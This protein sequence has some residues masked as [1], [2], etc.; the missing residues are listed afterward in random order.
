[1]IS[2]VADAVSTVERRTINSGGSWRA[3][4]ANWRQRTLKG[5]KVL[6]ERVDG[7]DREQMRALAD[8]LRNKWKSA[9][10]CWRRR[11]TQPSRSS[12][13]SPRRPRRSTPESRPALAGAGRQG[14]GRPDMAEAAQVTRT[15]AALDRLY[16]Q[17]EAML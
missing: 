7:L 15:A 16:A 14:G 2:S 12:R 8:S 10:V 9:V 1:M 4:W 5:V 3:D 6:A 13:P 17:V 11:R